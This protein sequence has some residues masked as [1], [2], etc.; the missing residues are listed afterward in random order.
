MV[1]ISMH[2]LQIGEMEILFIDVIM[3]KENTLL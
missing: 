2:L 3:K 1:N